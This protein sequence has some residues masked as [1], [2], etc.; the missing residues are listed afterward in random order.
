MRGRGI[1]VLLSFATRLL[2]TTCA[3]HAILSFG[4]QAKEGENRVHHS[5]EL[6]KCE[7]KIVGSLRQH[8]FL[9]RVGA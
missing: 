3:W 5:E 4:S 7:W 2:H 6:R 1:G 8:R 9:F